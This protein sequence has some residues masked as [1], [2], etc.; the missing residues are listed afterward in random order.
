M[1]ELKRARKFWCLAEIFRESDEF[2]RHLRKCG[3]EASGTEN[4]E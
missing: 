1:E 4:R 2:S 3:A